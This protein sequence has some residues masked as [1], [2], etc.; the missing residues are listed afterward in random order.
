MALF[1]SYAFVLIELQWHA[2]RWAPGVVR[3]VLSGE[4]PAR[5]PDRIIEELRSR[6]DRDGLITL[7]KPR[8]NS[9]AQ[10]QPGDKVRVINGPLTGLS[11]LVSTMQPHERV[12]ILLKLLGSIRPVELAEADVELAR[13]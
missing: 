6:E 2:A 3:L 8:L 9:G 7:P 5:V 1:P 12:A 11:G 13:E 4:Q 10:F